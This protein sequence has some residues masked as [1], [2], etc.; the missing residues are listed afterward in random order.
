[1]PQRLDTEVLP[2][3]TNFS[4]GQRQLLCLARALLRRAKVM[5]LDEATS[6]VD[7]ETDR[8]IQDIIRREFVNCTVLTV[9]HRLYT[10]IDC[11]KIMVL[12]RGVVV[13]Y[14]S[15][16]KLLEPL[17]L[18]LE[19]AE[20]AVAGSSEDEQAI[21]AFASLV[22]ET[23]DRRARELIEMARIGAASSMAE[24]EALSS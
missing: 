22:A 15:P 23:G 6:N 11:D 5:V 13:E 16:V 1:M 20:R 24:K 12:D 21:G 4:V 18:R 3:G 9:A 2:G 14:D 19:N 8:K 10:I 7:N 17:R